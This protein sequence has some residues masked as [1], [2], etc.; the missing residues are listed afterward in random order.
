MVR[1]FNVHFD[2]ML[3]HNI[4]LG[5]LVAACR[6]WGITDADALGLLAGSSPASAG[7]HRGAAPH[8]RRVPGGRRR[9]DDARRR[10]APP[11]PR[12]RAALDEYLADHAWRVVTDYTPR[13]LT[14]IEL[15]DVLVQ[16]IRARRRRRPRAASPMPAPFRAR[17]P[18]ADRDRFDDLLADARRCYGIR[19]DNVGITVMWPVGLLRRA[20]L[21]V[22]R[23]LVER[24]VLDEDWDALA[25]GEQELA[26][27]LRGDGSM[28]DLAKERIALGHRRRG[29]RRAAGARRLRG[30]R[31]RPVGVPRRHGR[32]DRR[33]HR[34][35]R[36]RGH[37]RARRCPRSGPATG[38]GVGGA[39][40]TGRACVAASPE[41][42][43]SRLEPGDVL[44]TT[45]TTPAYEAIMP[46][47]GAVVTEH[48]G[49]M[50]HTA[51]GGPRVRHRR[52][53]RRRRRHHA[54]SP[55]APRSRS[56][57]PAGRV[58]VTSAVPA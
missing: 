20:I 50:S 11:A 24:G 5:R 35:H 30:R 9:A 39:P 7:S 46:I 55:T 49:L 34:H 54:R 31:P 18:E 17:V 13:A 14:L 3:V 57:P 10:R 41:E 4:P 43:L 32:A 47:A 2:L 56:T 28:R 22:G 58:T 29:R 48:G 16:A 26:A 42:A 27:A 52:R 6:T 36:A 19:D 8:R 25:L 23:R 15:P 38:V 33:R 21:E 53:R 40:Y 1:G 44:V 37:G 51:L 45:I 12:P